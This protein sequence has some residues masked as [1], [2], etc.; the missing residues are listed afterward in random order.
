MSGASIVGGAYV[1]PTRW[2]HARQIAGD[3]VLAIAL[4]LALPL[5]WALLAG[6]LRLVLRAAGAL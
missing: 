6:A 3:L 4:V 1:A 5:G 2:Q